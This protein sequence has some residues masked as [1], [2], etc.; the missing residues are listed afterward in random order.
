MRVFVNKPRK[1]WYSAK[2]GANEI[3]KLF[4]YKGAQKTARFETFTPPPPPT[5]PYSLARHLPQGGAASQQLR[6]TH[7]VQK[8]T[9]GQG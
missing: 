1:I 5:I 6:T 2:S 3:Q 4:T 9:E 8:H 7:E